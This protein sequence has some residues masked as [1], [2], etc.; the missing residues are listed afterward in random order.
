M[1]LSDENRAGWKGKPLRLFLIGEEHL[2][3]PDALGR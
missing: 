3:Q 1:L 2:V